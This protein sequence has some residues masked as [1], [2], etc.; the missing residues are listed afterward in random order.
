MIQILIVGLLF[1]GAIAHLGWIFY[2][3][4][5]GEKSCAKGCGCDAAVPPHLQKQPEQ[6]KVIQ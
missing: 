4:W 3:S 1:A 6:K 2:K 5:K